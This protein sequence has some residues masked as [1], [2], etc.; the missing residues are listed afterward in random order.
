[1]GGWVDGWMGGYVY[2]RE[3][4]CVWVLVF[5]CDVRAGVRVCVRA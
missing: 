3:Y 5:V 2:M 1:M 4:T